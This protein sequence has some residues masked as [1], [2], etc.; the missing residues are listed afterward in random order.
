ME[1]M[2]SA[3]CEVRTIGAA[4]S[5]FRCLNGSRAN[6]PVLFILAMTNV[7]VEPFLKS[8]LNL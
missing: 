2:Q 5:M 7:V 3:Y 8:C 1:E 4:I 6:I